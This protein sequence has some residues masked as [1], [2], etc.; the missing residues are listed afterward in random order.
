ME[1]Q[2]ASVHHR[3]I[4]V[5]D[6][7]CLPYSNYKPNVRFISIPSRPLNVAVTDEVVDLVQREL[8]ISLKVA[9]VKKMKHLYQ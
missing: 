6:L 1:K 7:V 3:I 5:P 4:Q 8:A 2:I 9:T